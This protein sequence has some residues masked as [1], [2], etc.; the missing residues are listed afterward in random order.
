LLLEACGLFLPNLVGIATD[1]A[2]VMIGGKKGV[3]MLIRNYA[4]YLIQ[5][6]CIAHRL[7]L[8]VKDAE[9]CFDELHK[10]DTLSM[11]LYKYFKTSSVKVKQLENFCKGQRQKGFENDENS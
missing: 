4:P 2:A 1:R 8:A 10:L 7:S 5:I 11:D 9:S 3:G 6:H